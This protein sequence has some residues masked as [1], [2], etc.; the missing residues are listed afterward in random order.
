MLVSDE[1]LEKAL[2]Y[3]ITSVDEYADAIATLAGLEK[4][5][6]SLIATLM[7]AS[8]QTSAAAQEREAY[9]SEEYKI[10]VAGLVEAVRRKATLNAKRQA[11]ELLIE[12]WRS[13]Q[14]NNRALEKIR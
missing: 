12:L 5:E 10:H 13:E 7:K 8:G 14:A 1:R 11:E 2:R 9:A 3:L 6:K 4:N